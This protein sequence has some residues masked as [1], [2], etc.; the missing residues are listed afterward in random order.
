MHKNK[1]NKRRN[2][3]SNKTRRRDFCEKGV[4]DEVIRIRKL[5]K[6]IILKNKKEEERRK[7]KEEIRK[8]K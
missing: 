5:L 6:P 4:T 7:K 1:T 3:Y 2:K 8:K